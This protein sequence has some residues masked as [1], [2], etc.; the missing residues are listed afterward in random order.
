MLSQVFEN[1]KNSWIWYWKIE[2]LKKLSYWGLYSMKQ[3]WPILK[4][5]PCT[6]Y[7]SECSCSVSGVITSPRF[8]KFYD[9]LIDSTWLIQVPRG[10]YI[11]IDFVS[12]DVHH[13]DICLWVFHLSSFKAVNIS[14]LYLKNENCQR[15]PQETLIKGDV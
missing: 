1:Q 2:N 11:K 5:S 4:L 6:S 14:T 8:P 12:F 15:I 7:C 3:G 13:N 10:L 9:F